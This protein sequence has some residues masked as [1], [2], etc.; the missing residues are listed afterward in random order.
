MALFEKI[1][2]YFTRKPDLH[3]L[4]VFDNGLQG[5]EQELPHPGDAQWPE[6]FI[7]EIYDNRSFRIKYNIEHEWKEKKVVLL[8]RS[9]SPQDEESRLAFPL[10]D[11][12]ASNMEFKE[13][14]PEL[15]MQERNISHDYI[16]YV[17]RNI[18]KLQRKKNDDIL[19]G[20]YRDLSIDILNRSIISAELDSRNL[21]DW[22]S[23]FLKLIILGKKDNAKR[24][25]KF[26][27]AI[28]QSKDSLQALQQ[29]VQRTFGYKVDP[30]R[31]FNYEGMLQF[32]AKSL[33]YNSICGNLTL[34]PGDNYEQFKVFG[35]LDTINAIWDA[36]QKDEVFK[37]TLDEIAS[38]I[39]ESYIL[40][41]YG[42]EANYF[43]LTPKLA[44]PIAENL[45]EERLWAA[46]N[47]VNDKIRSM[48]NNTDDNQVK[49]TLQFL[50]RICDFYTTR[51]SLKINRLSTPQEYIQTYTSD[52]Y[53]LDSYYR[54]ALE[55]Y[56]DFTDENPIK[57]SLENAKKRLDNDYA[58]FTSDL[59]RNWINSFNR[60]CG[61]IH[62]LGF[63]CQ[64]E[65]Y[66]KYQKKDRKSVV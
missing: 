56:V 57:E 43:R 14:S 33:K 16:D 52:I 11:I 61:D 48:L 63:T 64:N 46:P 65:F 59:N 25:D 51:N 39:N 20:Y 2:D 47:E 7:Y 54:L 5:Y 24:K 4:F 23:I 6:N 50:A 29:M 10:L 32:I 30:N 3:V 60:D 17:K 28:Y 53:L 31:Q 37:E 1:T 62:K 27:N 41:I 34:I 22:P 58:K 18:T 21:L 13:D 49:G 40:K 15:F 55:L 8:V 42:A 19:K 26:F 35:A 36:G 9:A 38:D 44:Y 12:L 66:T 45:I